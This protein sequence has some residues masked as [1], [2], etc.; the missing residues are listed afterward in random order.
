MSL[1]D[2]LGRASG[3]IIEADLSAFH[4]RN[5]RAEGITTVAADCMLPLG[6]ST[7]T[8]AVPEGGRSSVDQASD[9]CALLTGHRPHG[10]AT[11]DVQRLLESGRRGRSRPTAAAQPPA[12]RGRKAAIHNIRELDYQTDLRRAI[13]R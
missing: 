9:S 5:E 2:D 4:P 7:G 10:T 12:R 1:L 8:A 3:R 11:T 6:F 13:N